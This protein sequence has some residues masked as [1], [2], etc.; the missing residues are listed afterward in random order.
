MTREESN[1]IHEKAKS[2]SRG[3]YQYNGYFYA[4]KDNCFIAFVTKDGECYRNRGGYNVS[5]GKVSIKKRRSEL[6]KWLN[7][8]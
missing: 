7:L 5:M 2:R 8:Q 1:A 3:V 4:V 6:L